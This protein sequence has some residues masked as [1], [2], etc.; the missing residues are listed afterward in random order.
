MALLNKSFA[1]IVVSF[2]SI[3]SLWYDKILREWVNDFDR[4]ELQFSLE[5]DSKD[6]EENG[7]YYGQLGRYPQLQNLI[8]EFRK[9]H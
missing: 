1:K 6:I 3:D 4:S 8:A 7:G 9:T 5:V 2:K